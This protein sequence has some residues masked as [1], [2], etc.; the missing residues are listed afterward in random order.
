MPIN[1]IP[2]V[3]PTNADIATAVAAPSAATIAAAVAA[4]SAATIAAAVAAPSSATIA[5]AVAAAVPNIGAIN[6]SVSTYAPSPH[7]W[8]LLGTVTPNN[9]ANSVT[10]SGLSGYRTYKIVS[11]DINITGQCGGIFLRI[12]GDATSQN[13]SSQGLSLG[14]NNSWSPVTG[15]GDYYTL[16]SGFG[17]SSG[18][19]SG[20]AYIYSAS[21]TGQKDISSSFSFNADS[22]SGGRS[23]A[24]G[25]WP[26][27]ATVNSLTLLNIYAGTF[28]GGKSIYLYGAN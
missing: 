15:V 5:S 16:S 24:T 17:S 21:S 1:N 7:A 12:N 6:S 10:F 11:A 2:G 4:P 14:N 20:V 25:S 26:G 27:T 13:Y 28:G 3:G 18:S 22:S 19:F 8:T 9:T 23:G